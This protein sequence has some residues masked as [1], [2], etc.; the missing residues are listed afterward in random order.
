ME[1]E[2]A[3]PAV[4]LG[5]FD[6]F[7]RE[8]FPS[9]ARSIALV[10]SDVGMG[11]DF[12]QES[13]ARLWQR[14]DAMASHEHARNFVFRV[15]LNEARSYM[16]RRRPLRLLGL[17]REPEGWPDPADGIT[18]RVAV[19]HALSSLSVRQRE[20]VVIVDYLG[21]DAASAGELL[22]MRPSMVR[23]QLVRGRT[24]LRRALE[25]EA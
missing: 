9:V 11:Q 23:V 16:R 22:G 20:C 19:F 18:N 5:E 10:I 21:Y 17:E 14:W 25:V 15:S 4:D 8:W 12:A 6:A 2:T 3:T 1:A 13:F 24:K 7:Y